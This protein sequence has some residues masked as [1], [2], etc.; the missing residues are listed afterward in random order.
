MNTQNRIKSDA[1]NRMNDKMKQFALT[2]DNEVN[3]ADQD[4]YLHKVKMRK[5][6]IDLEEEEN[7]DGEQF[8]F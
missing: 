2:C 4:T 5:F 8:S 6:I 3:E 7:K 1:F